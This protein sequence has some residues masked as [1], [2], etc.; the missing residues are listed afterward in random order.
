MQLFSFRDDSG[1]AAQTGTAMHAA[2]D[3]FHKTKD[4]IKAVEKMHSGKDQYP[5]AD[6]DAAARMFV[7]YVQDPRNATADVVLSEHPVEFVIK[8]HPDD[9]TKED[10]HVRGRLDQVRKEHGQLRVYD[11]K[12]STRDGF[13]LLSESFYQMAAYALGA[14]AVL[15]TRVDP[16]A[17]IL[18]RKYLSRGVDPASSPSGVFWNYVFRTEDAVHAMQGVRIAVMAI[19]T[20]TPWVGPSDACNWCHYGGIDRCVPELVKL[21]LKF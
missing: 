9:P 1:P 5:L 20:G 16:G 14:S 8:P 12:T 21:G 3:E 17:L 11:I 10:I 18:P 2:S 4:V 19:R 13:V 15:N 6:L 7:S